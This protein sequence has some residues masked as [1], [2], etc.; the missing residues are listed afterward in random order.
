[1]V[2]RAHGLLALRGLP[3]QPTHRGAQLVGVGRA[4]LLDGGLVEIHHAVRVHAVEVGVHLPRGLEVGDEFLVGRRVDF[5]RIRGARHVA[6]G[7]L[8]D[9][10]HV[11]RG[12]RAGRADDLHL[13]G[14]AELRQLA[15]EAHRV[16]PGHRG[17]EHLRLG[18]A[19][20]A[21]ERRV[22]LVIEG[23]VHLADRLG[24]LGFRR[25]LERRDRAAAHLVV[26][27]E[28]IHGSVGLFL[29]HPLGQRRGLHAGLGVDAEHVGRALVAGDRVGERHGRGGKACVALSD[30]ADGQRR[31]GV[32]RAGQEIDLRHLEELL[33]FL[34]RDV[35]VGLLVLVD[36][37]DLAPEDAA[38][39]V[40]LLDRQVD[41]PLHLLA[42]ARVGAGQRRD[43]A[44]LDRAR[45]CECAGGGEGC[46]HGRDDGQSFHVCLLVG[47]A[48]LGGRSGTVL[49]VG[50]GGQVPLY[51]GFLFSKNAFAPSL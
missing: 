41:A 33:G 1:M 18:C 24:A 49:G 46:G 40:D 45:L 16:V 17:V 20:L 26:R 22:V 11:L 9:R 8:A 36:R 38:L 34:H 47:G 43:D 39:V 51:L 4:G 31:A 13:L 2:A 5:A 14:E 32:H 19:H 21:E 3:F 37:L 29:H 27:P 12:D 48:A 44:D 10:G 35:G 23:R 50:R 15:E 30:L 6:F 42:D 28:V 7:R 25:R